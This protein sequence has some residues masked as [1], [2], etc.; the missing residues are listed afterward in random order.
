[1][2]LWN[3]HALLKHNLPSRSYKMVCITIVAQSQAD[4]RKLITSTNSSRVCETF[5]ACVSKIHKPYLYTIQLVKCL[6][7]KILE[8]IFVA[9]FTCSIRGLFLNAAYYIAYIFHCT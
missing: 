3:S 6:H 7:R 2:K 9:L 5:Y 8:I 4:P 1:M